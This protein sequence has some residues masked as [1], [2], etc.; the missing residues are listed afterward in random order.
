MRG[1]QQ[2]KSTALETAPNETLLLL[3][4]ETALE[5]LD[6]ASE[7]VESGDKKSCRE[8]LAFA[9]SAYSE[10]IISLD[11]EVAP[12]LSQQLNR[13]YLWCIRELAKAGSELNAARIEGVRKI[14]ASMLETWSE[15]VERAR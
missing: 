2:Y 1:I 12:E 8:H 10:L 15:A 4:L 3:L 9:R 11:H 6:Q 14:T 13:L 7:A 5:R